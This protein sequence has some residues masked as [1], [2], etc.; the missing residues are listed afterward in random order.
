M[1]PDAITVVVART[2]CRQ[3]RFVPA[4]DLPCERGAPC[5]KADTCRRLADEAVA[6]MRGLREGRGCRTP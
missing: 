5:P 4:D 3:Y 1:E 6:Y 2:L